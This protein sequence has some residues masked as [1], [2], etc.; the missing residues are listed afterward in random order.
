MV[1]GL[2]VGRHAS[3]CNDPVGLKGTRAG[4]VDEYPSTV[5]HAIHLP[6]L[7]LAA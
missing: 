4:L 2:G 3:K 1:L 7:L 5:A 6:Q